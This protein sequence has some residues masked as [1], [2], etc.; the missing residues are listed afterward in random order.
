MKIEGLPRGGKL[1]ISGNVVNVPSNVSTTVST[2]PRTVNE[3]EI[4]T[5]QLK[6]KM[7]YNHSYHLANIHP[8]RVLKAAKWSVENSHLHKQDDIVINENFNLMPQTTLQAETCDTYDECH[9]SSDD[10]NETDNS[11]DHLETGN[12]ETLLDSPIELSPGQMCS[13]A[14]AEENIPL[15]ISQDRNAEELSFPTLF[16]GLPT[17]EGFMDLHLYYSQVCKRKLRP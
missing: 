17:Q 5:L 7:D 6:R 16:C 10:W 8:L 1:R 9:E 12:V 13:I 15:G 3:Q 14:S 4:I 11:S 2:L